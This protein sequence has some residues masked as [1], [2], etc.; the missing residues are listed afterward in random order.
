MVAAITTLSRGKAYIKF[1]KLTKLSFSI[2]MHAQ[3]RRQE[4][5]SNIPLP[6]CLLFPLLPHKH[7]N[8][9]A[10]LLYPKKISAQSE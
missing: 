9:Y 7:L 6:C 1:S 8:F 3:N 2:G 10:H 5:K 4:K